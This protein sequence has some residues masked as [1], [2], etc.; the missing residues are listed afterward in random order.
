MA[1]P[2]SSF[3]GDTGPEALCLCADSP[4]PSPTPEAPA[5]SPRKSS[6]H[7]YG[8]EAGLMQSCVCSPLSLVT[9]WPGV[10]PRV[11][12]LSTWLLSLSPQLPCPFSRWLSTVSTRR[13]TASRFQPRPWVPPPRRSPLPF[14]L[15]SLSRIRAP[16]GRW[17]L[18]LP[19]QVLLTESGPQ[20]QGHQRPLPALHGAP[21]AP[22]CVPKGSTVLTLHLWV[23]E[24]QIRESAE[25]TGRSSE[26]MQGWMESVECWFWRKGTVP[27]V[28]G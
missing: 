28:L 11:W 1:Q 23:E 9:S 6:L 4:C 19:R 25:S 16:W 2:L 14:L 20:G 17:V 26:G 5:G 12:P 13:G 15:L 8:F 27:Q 10:S 7:L 18:Q 22:C 24:N 3:G 21:E